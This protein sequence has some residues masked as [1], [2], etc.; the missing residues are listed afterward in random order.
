MSTP[1]QNISK[2]FAAMVRIVYLRN[3]CSQFKRSH[4]NATVTSS[5]CRANE[6]S[7]FQLVLA[8]PAGIVVETGA[9]FRPFPRCLCPPLLRP[10]LPALSCKHTRITP[11]HSVQAFTEMLFY[12]V[13]S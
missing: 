1:G 3:V 4:Q 10:L 2:E 8:A 11:T 9:G 5:P 12:D 13:Q 6:S 7:R